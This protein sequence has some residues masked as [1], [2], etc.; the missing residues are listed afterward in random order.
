VIIPAGHLAQAFEHFLATLLPNLF[1]GRTFAGHTI[2]GRTFGQI[3][4]TLFAAPSATLSPNFWT[5]HRRISG[6]FESEFFSSHFRHFDRQ[7]SGTFEPEFLSSHS[8]HLVVLAISLSLSG[9]RCRHRHRN[10]YC[11]AH[12][13][14]LSARR[15]HCHRCFKYVSFSP[16]CRHI[17]RTFR[18]NNTRFLTTTC[19]GTSFAVQSS[20]TC[21]R[22]LR[23][24]R[25][26]VLGLQQYSHRARVVRAHVLSSSSAF[27]VQSS[28]T[29]CP[30]QHRSTVITTCRHRQPRVVNAHVISTVIPHCPRG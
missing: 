18:P 6:T 5:Y 11:P 23:Q 15:P 1:A 13:S 10:K 29:C 17:R 27:A 22:S 19:V 4:G 7:I 21:R 14:S 25:P 26:R 30:C 3:P 24:H 16:T 8:R 28:I 20:T 9:R 2:I 12:V